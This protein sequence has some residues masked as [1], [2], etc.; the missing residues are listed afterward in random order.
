MLSYYL[1]YTYKKYKKKRK[2]E[3]IAKGFLHERK[4]SQKGKTLSDF[5]LTKSRC[6][7]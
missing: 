4:T 7:L 2:K 3:G 1:F 5:S 6:R